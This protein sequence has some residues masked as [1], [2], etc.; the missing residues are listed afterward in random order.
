MAYSDSSCD[1]LTSSESTTFAFLLSYNEG[2]KMIPLCHCKRDIRTTHQWC[3]WPTHITLTYATRQTAITYCAMTIFEETHK[4]C[5]NHRTRVYI[6]CLIELWLFNYTSMSWAV[7]KMLGLHGHLGY[8]SKPNKNSF[9]VM[10]S[11]RWT[12]TDTEHMAY[13]TVSSMQTC[14]RISY[15]EGTYV[16][17][18]ARSPTF[19]LHAGEK[20]SPRRMQNPRG[21]V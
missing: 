16:P 2:M 6:Y 17:R 9:K 19:S 8:E 18:D 12:D 20:R 7:K 1:N 13:A 15:V 4:D 11:V 14:S 10:F 5:M 3:L 21:Y